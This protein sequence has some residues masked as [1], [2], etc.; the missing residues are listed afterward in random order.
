[1]T[2][3]I[4]NV[5]ATT[6]IT[7][8]TTLHL[9]DFTTFSVVMCFIIILIGSIG[10]STVIFIFGKKWKNLR[11][12]ELFMLNLAISDLI[13][14]VIVPLKFLIDLLELEFPLGSIGELKG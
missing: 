12:C 9:E 10:N 14:S 6:T 8:T 7:P 13:G 5:T 3:A 2:P 4:S 11:N 1:M